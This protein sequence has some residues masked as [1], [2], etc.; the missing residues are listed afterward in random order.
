[1]LVIGAVAMFYAWLLYT[2]FW[3]YRGHADAEDGSVHV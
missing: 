1:M 3:L 2:A